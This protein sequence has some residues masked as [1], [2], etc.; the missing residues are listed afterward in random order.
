MPTD[1]Q[2]AGFAQVPLVPAYPAASASGTGP[3]AP[4]GSLWYRV[5]PSATDAQASALEW[6]VHATNLQPTRAYR[7]DFVVDGTDTYSV[8]SGRSD[9]AGSMTSHGTAT[10]FA[11]DYCVSTVT[12]P[13]AIAGRHTLAFTLKSDGSGSGPAS[14]PSGPFTE[15]GR[16]FPCHGNGDGLFENWLVTQPPI[17]IRTGS[18]AR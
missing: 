4:A 8:G 14:A 6:Y 17:T 15:P 13:Q 3:H 18:P 1:D 5:S 2:L 11:D 12:G 9:A 7:F 16:T 10:R